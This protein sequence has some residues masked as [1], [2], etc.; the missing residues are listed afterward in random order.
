MTSHPISS[1]SGDSRIGMILLTIQRIGYVI[2][3]PQRNRQVTENIWTVRKYHPPPVE[4]IKLLKITSL[5]PSWSL[6]HEETGSSKCVS[7]RNRVLCKQPDGDLTPNSADE[8]HGKGANWVIESKFIPDGN[9][10][11]CEE[12]C[13]CSNECGNV[14]WKQETASVD[15]NC[16]QS[17]NVN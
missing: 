14:T 2:I 17:F 3:S 7:K 1:S 10:R 16:W 15:C 5:A 13:E 12:C 8:M 9:G 11:K 6:T 4:L